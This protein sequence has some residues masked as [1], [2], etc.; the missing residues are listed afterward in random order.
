MIRSKGNSQQALKYLRK[1]LE[2]DEGL[3]DRISMARDYADLGS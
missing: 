2:I 3:N 1:A